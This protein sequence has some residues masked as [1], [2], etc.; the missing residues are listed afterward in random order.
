MEESLRRPLLLSRG[1]WTTFIDPPLSA[2][3]L[4]SIVAL[5]AVKSRRE[6]AFQ[7]A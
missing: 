7:E 6:V 3:L 2:A 5:P 4:I 1:D